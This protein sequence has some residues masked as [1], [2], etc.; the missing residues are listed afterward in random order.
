VFVGAGPGAADLLTLRAVDCL[1]RA[2]V[3]VH[4]R[5]VPAALL[6]AVAT[7]AVFEANRDPARRTDGLRLEV[8]NARRE[9]GRTVFAHVEPAA[10]DGR[11]MRAAIAAGVLLALAGLA[12]AGLRTLA[13]RTR[14]DAFAHG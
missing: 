2:D 14:E 6:D 8:A 3:I 7:T 10:D 4:D 9:V 12:L 1:R 11:P 5:L 13:R